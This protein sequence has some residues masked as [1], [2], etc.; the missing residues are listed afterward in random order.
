[1]GPNRKRNI[2]RE[3]LFIQIGVKLLLQCLEG[4][5][6]AESISN[7]AANNEKMDWLKWGNSFVILLKFAFRISERK[8]WREAKSSTET[9]W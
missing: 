7:S 3:L 8:Y 5:E 2:F 9:I 1:M 4:V 6:N